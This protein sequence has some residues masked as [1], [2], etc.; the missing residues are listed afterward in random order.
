M[1]AG[2]KDSKAQAVLRKRTRW[3]SPM[4][5]GLQVQQAMEVLSLAWAKRLAATIMVVRVEAKRELAALVVIQS[6][7]KVAVLAARMGLAVE[8]VQ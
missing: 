6:T 5:M 4:A 2:D 7:L 8:A 3:S 1:L